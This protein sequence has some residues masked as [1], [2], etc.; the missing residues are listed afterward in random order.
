MR[1]QHVLLYLAALLHATPVLMQARG[2]AASAAPR[3]IR[4]GRD[5]IVAGVHCGPTGRAYAALHLNGTLEECPLAA[6]SVVEGNALAKGSWIRLTPEGILDGAWLLRDAE[7]QGLPCKG[8]GYK[9][10]AVRFHPDG[11][12][13]LCYLSRAATIDSIPCK[14][15]AFITELSGSTHVLLHHNGRLRSCRVARDVTYRGEAIGGGARIWLD[16]EGAMVSAPASR[17][18]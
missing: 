2:Q 11:R 7:L 9:G 4:L 13:S 10:W 15:G 12:L 16:V 3:R 1:S 14:R 17:D 8:T 18:E 5:T 6:D